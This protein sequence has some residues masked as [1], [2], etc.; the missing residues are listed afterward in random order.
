MGSVIL[1]WKGT[2]ADREA[3]EELLPFVEELAARNEARWASPPPRPRFLGVL[4]AQREEDA[5][6][7]AD[8]RRFDG[9]IAGRILIALDVDNDWQGL[10]ESAISQGVA[11]LR[12][13]PGAAGFSFLR[14][15]RAALRG[16]D[17]RLFDPR[18]LYPGS[19]RLSFVFL[20][21]EVPC[22]N[23]RL[24]AVS[25]RDRCL[26]SGLEAVR[27]A[28]WY[29][30]GPHV[31]LRYLLEEWSDIFFSWLKTFFVPD[32]AYWRYED[33]P[34][35]ETLRQMFEEYIDGYGERAAR[36]L[37]FDTL[38]GRFEEQAD[39]WTAKM[40]SF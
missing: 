15:D 39:E 18:D 20:E 8:I 25:D 4:S 34:S 37:I 1:T 23:G 24:V 27:A 22:L 10:A 30:E 12:L 17:F 13:E 2:C 35:F 9:E 32:L 11:A 36:R 5:P 38:L 26:L 3:R 19:D 29:L 28:D 40:Q 31:H 16:I 14:L 21:S 6:R 7:L 33:L